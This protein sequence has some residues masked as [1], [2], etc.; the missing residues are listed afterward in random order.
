MSPHL[1]H[2]VAAFVDGELDFPHRE[3]ALAHLS[4]CA[5]CRAAVEQQR[6][7]KTRVQTL[8]GAEPSA[9][10]ISALTRLP[11][12]PG[13]DAA[14]SPHWHVPDGRVRRGGLLAAGVGS[15][16]AGFLGMAYVVGG[17]GPAEQTPVSPPVGQFS[18]EYAGSDQPMPFTDPA[19]D[20]LPVLTDRSAVDGP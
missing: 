12:E 14:P 8:P 7:V 11:A 4:R 18:V 3:K 17:A 13:P 16:A 6:L 2:Q 1:G 20:V 15:V 5:Q 19:M 10:L 9:D